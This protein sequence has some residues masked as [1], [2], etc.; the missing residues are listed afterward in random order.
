[1]AN[2]HLHKCIPVQLGPKVNPSSDDS[3]LV[4]E[5]SFLQKSVH[6]PP[7]CVRFVILCDSTILPVVRGSRDSIQVRTRHGIIIHFITLSTF[8][9]SWQ[10]IFYM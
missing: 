9:P 4:C 8:N 10:I 1:M 2:K 7:F 3:K 6:H 5:M